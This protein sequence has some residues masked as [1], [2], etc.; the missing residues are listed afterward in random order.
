MSSISNLTD[1]LTHSL[2]R[3]GKKTLSLIDRALYYLIPFESPKASIISSSER[4]D[5]LE[6]LST[7]R[8]VLTPYL[9]IDRIESNLLRSLH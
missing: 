6:L 5:L 4:H 3:P 7:H 2:R 1:E 8:M 9:D